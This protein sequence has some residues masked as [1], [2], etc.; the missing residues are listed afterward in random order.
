MGNELK[1]AQDRTDA[2]MRFSRLHLDELLHYTRKGSGDDFDRSHT[3]SF[4]FQLI[5]VRDAFLQELNLHYKCKLELHKVSIN[6]LRGYFRKNGT[7]CDELEELRTLEDKKD[8]WLYA[9]IEMRNHSTHR[10]SVSREFYVGGSEDGQ[11]HLINPGTNE[12]LG[13]DYASTFQM[14]CREMEQLVETLRDSYL[15]KIQLT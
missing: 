11:V 1:N 3:E 9:A 6:S 12:S 10:R 2:K 13:E 4:L 14:W 7:K 5:G 15:K 8:S